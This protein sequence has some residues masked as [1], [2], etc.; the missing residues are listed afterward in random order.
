SCVTAA[1]K[2]PDGADGHW[3]GCPV[4]GRFARPRG[5]SRESLV[6]RLDQ[7]SNNR[8]RAT[9]ASEEAEVELD[10]NTFDSEQNPGTPPA[11]GVTRRSLLA[12]AAQV[13]AGLTGASLL[14][15]CG[16]SSSP[17]TSGTA[18]TASNNPAGALSELPGG[19]PKKGGTFTVGVISGGQ[20][21]NLFPGT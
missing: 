13:G 16:S 10:S 6:V 17:T 18:P 12:G 3:T 15:A 2:P 1:I 5:H 7:R 11:S 4:L 20:E 14:A 19:T 8:H 21:E 9:M